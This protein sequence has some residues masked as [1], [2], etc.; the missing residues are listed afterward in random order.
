MTIDP[1]KVSL[2]DVDP[3]SE[4]PYLHESFILHSFIPMRYTRRQKPFDDPNFIGMYP[5]GFRIPTVL[6]LVYTFLTC[7]RFLSICCRQHFEAFWQEENCSSWASSSFATMCSTLI[8]SNIL[9]GSLLYCCLCDVPQQ[10]QQ[11]GLGWS[12]SMLYAESTM[13]F[14]SRNGSYQIYLR[15][16]STRSACAVRAD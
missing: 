16:V 8:N 14:F 12:E 9:P 10:N 7:R 13:L 6:R 5:E 15:N 11:C 4:F 1:G 2:T 3:H